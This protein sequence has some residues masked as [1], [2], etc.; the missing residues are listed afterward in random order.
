MWVICST[1]VACALQSKTIEVWKHVHP[2]ALANHDLK[3]QLK[4]KQS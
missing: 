1:D 2:Q 3:G 4:V